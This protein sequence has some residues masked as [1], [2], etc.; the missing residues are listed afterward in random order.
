[1]HPFSPNTTGKARVVW[2]VV[3]VKHL[4]YLGILR[5]RCVLYTSSYVNLATLNSF[6]NAMNSLPH[7]RGL[8][9]VILHLILRR[10]P[11][12]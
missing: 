11:S 4:E 10:T 5:H 9:L 6:E 1:M 3:Y 2:A 8:V 7:L 12:S